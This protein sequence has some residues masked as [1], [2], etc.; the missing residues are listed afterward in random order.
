MA[1]AIR[2]RGPD[3]T[4]IW[5]DRN[6]GLAHVRLSIIDT[7]NAGH[8][9]LADPT[10]QLIIAFNGE[11]YN[12]RELKKIHESDGFQFRSRT[13]TEV[14][15]AQ[16]LKHGADGVS[17]LNGMFAFALWNCAENTL[18][19]CRDRLGIK[20]LYYYRD[21]E[22]IIFGSEIKAILKVK[23]LNLDLDED[24]LVRYFQFLSVPGPSSIFKNIRK[25]GPG[26]I[27]TVRE[28]ELKFRKYWELPRT[29]ATEEMNVENF[30]ADFELA[31]SRS[32][33]S[34]LIADVPIGSFLSG[35][36]DSGTVTALAVQQTNEKL[37]T[38]S[39]TFPG[40]ASLDEGPIASQVAAHLGTEHHSLAMEMDFTKDL[41]KLIAHCDEPFAVSSS[42]ALF[43]MARET[44]RKVKV[45]LTG[46]GGDEVLAGYPRHFY[47]SKLQKLLHAVPAS[48]KKPLLN[49]Y[50]D[51]V[52]LTHLNPLTFPGKQMQG[53]TEQL[54]MDDASHYEK[55]MGQLSVPALS[56][57]F[58]KNCT[59]YLGTSTIARAFRGNPQ[60]DTVNRRLYTEMKTSLVDEMLMKVDR[61][62]MAFGL[63][64]RVP[65]LDHELVEL[66]S[67]VPGSL[68]TDGI[69]GKIP[70]R[71]LAAKILPAN[72]ARLPKQGFEIPLAQWF[73]GKY[74]DFLGD[75]LFSK[76]LAED[77]ILNQ[78]TVIKLFSDHMREKSNN[79]N[80]LYAVLIWKLWREQFSQ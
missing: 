75:H 4:G 79:A 50:N 28:R 55:L 45:V 2:H 42:L 39:V 76:H 43:L 71:K 32:V 35:G 21:E 11:I 22:K 70:L 18:Y 3:G 77:G 44:S 15:L 65:F 46:D 48:F 56:A 80:R 19:L 8:Q 10:G 30:Q 47:D 51:C 78:K 14:I 64:A 5:A 20:P 41:P 26:E 67:T 40:F 69:A 73:R 37:K 6:T 68:K 57:L 12:Y 58:N 54:L 62:T 72:V 7:S 25:L 27:L 17:K 60:L 24:A 13:D 16:F 34:H 49:S 31:L 23:G 52:W 38:F 59:K 61:M 63:E 1:E 36:L 33:K 74:R 29:Q 66:M 53:L 9:P